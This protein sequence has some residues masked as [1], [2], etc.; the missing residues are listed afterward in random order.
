MEQISRWWAR[1]KAHHRH[2]D[3]KV[4]HMRV[5]CF[6]DEVTPRPVITVHCDNHRENITRN[7]FEL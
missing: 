7:R 6:S 4:R 5:V 2:L 1:W 3:N